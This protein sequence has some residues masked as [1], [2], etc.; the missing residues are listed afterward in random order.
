MTTARVRLICFCFAFFLLS[1]LPSFASAVRV[2]RLSL[3]QGDV[4]IDRNSGDGWEQAIVN[5]P[6]VAGARIYAAQNAKAELEFEDGSSV[7]L[8]GPAQIS[9]IELSSAPNGSPVNAIQVDSGEVYVNA[10]LRNHDDFR[11]SAYSGE[12]FAVTKPSR[13]RFTVNEQTASLAVADGEAVAQN[14]SDNATIHGGETYNYILG[15]PASAARLE[16]VPPHPEDAWNQQRESNNDQNASAGSQYPGAPYS[17][18]EDAYAPGMADLGQYGSYS[19]IPGYGES[20]QPNDVGPDWDPFDNGAWSYYPDWGWTFVSAYPWGWTP[21]YCGNWFYLNGRGWWWHR[22]PWHGPGVHPRPVLSGALP[23]G[24][25]APHP[26]AGIAHGTVAVAG[27]HLAVGPIGTTHASAVSMSSA[28]G[29]AT[30]RARTGSGVSTTS[31]TASSLVHPSAMSHSGTLSITGQ[32]GS[33]TL[34]VPSPGRNGYEVRRPPVSASVPRSVSTSNSSAYSSPYKSHA[35]NSYAHTGSSAPQ[36]YN[37]PVPP[38]E[39]ASSPPP[40]GPAPHVSPSNFGGASTHSASSGGATFHSGGGGGGGF[41]SSG[42][43]GGGGHR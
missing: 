5:M 8:A 10:R 16:S 12:S 23:H 4:Q 9:L 32:K 13:L 42:G 34:R 17:G 40:A 36:I 43:G 31:A 30:S 20:W 33:Y 7:R 38:P 3:V 21:F 28:G 15:Q 2:V 18:S 19:D 1:A 39:R 37:V 29:G 6:V 26:P 22:G 11:I 14:A 35:A 24:F 27:S 41:H 25:N